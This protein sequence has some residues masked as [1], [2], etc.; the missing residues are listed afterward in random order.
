MIF[1]EIFTTAIQALRGN[2]LRTLLTML[3]IVIGITSVILIVSLGQGA[4]ASITSQISSLGVNQIYVAPGSP[5]DDAFEST[6]NMDSLSLDDTNRLS[7]ELS[8]IDAVS[9]SVSTR[10]LIT[11]NGQKVNASVFGIQPDYLTVQTLSMNQ[12]IFIDDK[13]INSQGRVVVLGP[14]IRDKLFGE[15]ADVVGTLVRIDNKPFR[16]IGVTEPKGGSA[17]SNPDEYVYIPITTAM[18]QVIGIDYVQ[19]I[20]IIATDPNNVESIQADIKQ[21]LRSAHG[22]AE[23]QPADFQMFS[24]KQA[25]STVNNVTGLLSTFLSAIAGISLVVGGIGIMNIMLVTVTERTREIGLLKAIGAKRRDILTQFIAEALVLTFLG[26]VIGI[27][28]GYGLTFIVAS[29]INIP[30]VMKLSTIG[31]ALGV[32]A[33]VGLLFG[34]YPAQKAA[35]LNPIDALRFE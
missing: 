27:V 9:A 25:L 6:G 8:G 23:G 20:V 30:L 4:T 21:I 16:I 11:A 28:C 26:G 33:G 35:K 12:G 19:S 14:T 22:I 15:G 17:F 7:E 32:A 5:N 18:K 10:L 1:I 2:L 31:L 29:L 34:Y 24:S 3:G 13:D